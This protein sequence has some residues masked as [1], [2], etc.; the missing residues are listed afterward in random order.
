VNRVKAP[1][2]LRGTP[3]P[4]RDASRQQGHTQHTDIDRNYDQTYIRTIANTG[5]PAPLG[6]S[7]LVHR[8]GN[9]APAFL[10]GSASPDIA[11]HQD[12]GSWT[13]PTLAA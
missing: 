13:Y 5:A 11:Q 12:E 1:Y 10:Y 3:S 9:R 2:P 8:L 6:I 4:H 7:N